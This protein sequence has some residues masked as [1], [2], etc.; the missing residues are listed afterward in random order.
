MLC[1]NYLLFLVVIRFGC[2][3]YSFIHV[4]IQYELWRR[5]CRYFLLI[6]TN[7]DILPLRQINVLVV[8]II[9][10][11]L[12]FSSSSPIL[13]DCREKMCTA[14]TECVRTLSVIVSSQ[15]TAIA[16]DMWRF[17]CFGIDDIRF[18]WNRIHDTNDTLHDMNGSREKAWIVYVLNEG[19]VYVLSSCVRCHI[20]GES[21]FTSDYKD[22]KRWTKNTFAKKHSNRNLL[23]LLHTE[24]EPD[25]HIRTSKYL[26]MNSAHKMMPVDIILFGEGIHVWR[27]GY[28]KWSKMMLQIII[29]IREKLYKYTII[30][31][32]IWRP[33][34]HL[35][36]E[37]HF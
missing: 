13:S 25:S 17:A 7:Y 23:H 24:I 12:C 11:A 26:W 16:L 3:W 9:D 37:P 35:L 15:S 20:S 29:I 5:Y 34:G 30:I 31:V 18:R 4:F 8:I 28:G 6:F 14:G 2:V 36:C 27:K 32:P 33:F 1:I 10:W 22:R 19:R 21:L